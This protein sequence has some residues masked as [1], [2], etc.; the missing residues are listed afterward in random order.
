MAPEGGGKSVDTSKLLS[1]SSDTRSVGDNPP[2]CI[3]ERNISGTSGVRSGVLN[4]EGRFD[5]E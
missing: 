2:E 4:D 1:L 3:S 5:K